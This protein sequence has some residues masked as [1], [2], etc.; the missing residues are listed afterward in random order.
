MKTQDFAAKEESRGLATAEGQQKA[1]ELELDALWD[2]M[3]ARDVAYSILRAELESQWQHT[4][5][6]S[7]KLHTLEKDQ[8]QSE[9]EKET[10]RQQAAVE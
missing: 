8:A 2:Q 7:E 9:T 10:L 3:K 4:E 5:N 1:T 6:A